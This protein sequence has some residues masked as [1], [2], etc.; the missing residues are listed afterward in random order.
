MPDEISEAAL[1]QLTVGALL[2]ALLLLAAARV[3]PLLLN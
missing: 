2:A 1:S 3:A